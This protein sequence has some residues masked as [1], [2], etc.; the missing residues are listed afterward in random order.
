MAQ[1]MY[2]NSEVIHV[3]Q[4]IISDTNAAGTDNNDKG[5]TGSDSNLGVYT[6][7]NWKGLYIGQARS[8]ANYPGTV[9]NGTTGSVQVQL[10]GGGTGSL[11]ENISPG[12]VLPLNVTRV[13]HNL[14]NIADG[15]IVGLN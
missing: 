3:N 5:V 10:K 2:N 8:E 4:D 13:Y 9:V 7:G 14:T 6:S 15:G 1:P 11:F 12:T